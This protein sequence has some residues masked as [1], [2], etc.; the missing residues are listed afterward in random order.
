MF[1]RPDRLTSNENNGWLQPDIV[2]YINQFHNREKTHLQ[3]FHRWLTEEGRPRFLF[4]FQPRGS[5]FYLNFLSLATFL[6]TWT[7]CIQKNTDLTYFSL[8]AG[9]NV[10]DKELDTMLESGQTDVFTQNVSTHKMKGGRQQ[11]DCL[12]VRNHNTTA[13]AVAGV[14]RQLPTDSSSNSTSDFKCHV[15]NEDLLCCRL[16][17]QTGW[18][19]W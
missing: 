18:Q 6:N 14:F 1:Y 2:V 9:T 16:S 12:H 17:A 13:P 3:K 10:T 7:S 15:W 8:S 4:W 11:C 5:F 19:I